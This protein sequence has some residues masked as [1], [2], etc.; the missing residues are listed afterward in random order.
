MGVSE[1][2][3]AISPWH[4]AQTLLPVAEESATHRRV[5]SAHNRKGRKI[6]SSVTAQ[7]HCIAP[8]AFAFVAR[9]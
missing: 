2:F 6:A 7:Y 8:D 9:G 4:S 3:R 5:I 1:Y